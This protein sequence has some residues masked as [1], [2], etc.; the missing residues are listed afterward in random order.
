MGTASNNE[1]GSTMY[2]NKSVASSLASRCMYVNPRYQESFGSGD[3]TFG[4]HQLGSNCNL[5]RVVQ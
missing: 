2:G 5:A 3:I 1:A 4:P